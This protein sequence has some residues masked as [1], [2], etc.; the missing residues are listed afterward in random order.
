MPLLLSKFGSVKDAFYVRQTLGISANLVSIES[1]APMEIVC[2]DY[3][4]LERS[5]GGVENDLVIADHFSMYAQAIP[6]K[7][8]RQRQLLK[9]FL[10]SLLCYMAFQPDCTAKIGQHF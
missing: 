2:L 10:T 8:R 9:F 3:L 6:T 4:S 1:N 7:N 5:K